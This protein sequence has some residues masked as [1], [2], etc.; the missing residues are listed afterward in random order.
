VHRIILSY[1]IFLSKTYVQIVFHE[2]RLVDC[3]RLMRSVVCA[4]FQYSDGDITL[5]THASCCTK[6][7]DINDIIKRVWNNFYAEMVHDDINRV[8]NEYRSKVFRQIIE[9]NYIRAL[10]LPLSRLA[11]Y[12]SPF[13]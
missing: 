10:F 6:R 11:F 4:Y 8:K 2:K 9:N 13:S 5:F 12:F 3:F 1:K 7:R